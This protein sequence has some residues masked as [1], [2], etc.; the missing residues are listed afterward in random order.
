LYFVKSAAIGRFLLGIAAAKVYPALQLDL[1][2]ANFRFAPAD[3]NA[4]RLQVSHLSGGV[5]GWQGMTQS[6]R[7]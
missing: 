7:I 2:R 3:F 6:K 5:A 1:S 4:R